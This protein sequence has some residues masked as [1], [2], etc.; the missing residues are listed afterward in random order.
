MSEKVFSE[1][2]LDQLRSFP[3]ISA[4]ELIRYF[5]P[6]TAESHRVPATA[7]GGLRAGQGAQLAWGE[8]ICDTAVAPESTTAVKIASVDFAV[9]CWGCR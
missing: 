9:T 2:Q 4:D 1:E 6:T 3:E 5:T 8:G 7:G